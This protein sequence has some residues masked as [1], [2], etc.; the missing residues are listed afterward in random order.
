VSTSKAKNRPG[1]CCSSMAAIIAVSALMFVMVFV[2][3]RAGVRV[4]ST[5][6]SI[7]TARVNSVTI[8]N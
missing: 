1:Y 3:L 4:V 6:E 2:M 8:G 5:G 7:T